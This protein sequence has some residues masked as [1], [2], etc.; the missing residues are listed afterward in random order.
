M[1]P[2][3]R[4]LARLVFWIVSAS[5]CWL[6]VIVL[7]DGYWG[8]GL[9]GKISF[10][11]SLGCAFSMIWFLP[12]VVYAPWLF[13]RF[14]RNDPSL[15]PNVIQQTWLCRLM[16]LSVECL[17]IGL[18]LSTFSPEI[19]TGR[20]WIL[21]YT[22]A[23]C[24]IVFTIFIGFWLLYLWNFT[25]E[26]TTSKKLCKSATN[27]FSIGVTLTSITRVYQ[28]KSLTKINFIF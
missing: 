19:Y 18:G 4:Q 25:W 13:P 1:T 22:I 8:D 3:L 12:W 6:I 28:D 10:G 20:G 7:K 2:C 17:L 26:I 9:I 27:S 16:F 21:R 14:L 15:P 23:P 11:L 24:A 5:Y